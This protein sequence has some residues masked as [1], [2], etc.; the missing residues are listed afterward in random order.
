MDLS[1][2]SRTLVGPAGRIVVAPV[3]LS[4]PAVARFDGDDPS[5]CVA[6][7]LGWAGAPTDQ[8]R[9]WGHGL[10]SD[11]PE[12]PGWPWGD[13]VRYV[14]PDYRWEIAGF[15]DTVREEIATGRPTAAE[16]WFRQVVSVLGLDPLLDRR[17]TELSGGETA[18]VVIAAHLLSGARCLVLDRVLGEID[19]SGRASLLAFWRSLQIPALLVV[20]DDAAQVPA[21]LCARLEQGRVRW[22]APAEDP[23]GDAPSVDP[24]APALRFACVE[25]SPRL[26]GPADG[27]PRLVLDRFVVC[28]GTRRVV[29]PVT[30]SFAGGGCVLVTGPNGAGKSTL[31]EGLVGLLDVEGRGRLEG[32]CREHASPALAL[33]PQ[34]ARTDVTEATLREEMRFA[35]GRRAPVSEVAARLALSEA[36]LD[37]PLADDMRSQKFASVLCALLRG[38]PCCLLDEPTLYLTSVQKVRIA[39]WTV[40]FVRHGG[41]ALCASHDRT[42]L[43]AI[44]RL[45]RRVPAAGHDTEGAT[46]CCPWRTWWRGASRE[47]VG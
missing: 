15:W 29:G 43:E 3:R 31:L 11:A 18:R 22:Q 26:T 33:A 1:L 39:V 28:R 36:D 17:P 14:G 46:P 20:V 35:L 41:I 4:L 7:A 42:F 44:V 34:D 2:P 19:W 10:A 5:A 47:P 38:A 23:N 32:G 16:A 25:P 12:S 27:L 9:E 24:A 40:D 30:T 45:A 37:R 8:L 6:A 13:D 21:T